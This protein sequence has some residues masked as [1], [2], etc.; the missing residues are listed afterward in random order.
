MDKKLKSA[1]PPVKHIAEQ[2]QAAREI[3]FIAQSIIDT[4]GRVDAG[5]DAAGLN[6]TNYQLLCEHSVKL[7]AESTEILGVLVDNIDK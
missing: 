6:I 7:L 1:I 3:I 5:I 2:I 4:M